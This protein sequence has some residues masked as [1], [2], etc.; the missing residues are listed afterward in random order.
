M[1]PRFTLAASALALIAAFPSVA[2]ENDLDPIVV[3]ATRQPAKENQLLS[4]VSVISRQEI[5]QAAQSTLAE[6]LGR[7]PGISFSSDGGPG[8]SQSLFIRGTN[9]DQALVLVDG[10]RLGSATLGTTALSRIPL[11][12]IDHIEILRGPASSLYGADAIGGVIQIFTRKGGGP[13]SF[14]GELAYGTNDTTRVVAGVNGSHEE[15]R[16]S[17]QYTQDKTDGFSNINDSRSYAFNKDLDGFKNESY[18]ANI[19]YNFNADHEISI[20]AFASD[21]TNRYDGGYGASASKDYKNKLNISGTSLTLR[22]RFLPDWQ[23]TLRLGQGVDNTE[24]LTDGVTAS[25]VRTESNQVQWQN[26]INLPLGKLLA[27]LEQL[28]QKV[29]ATQTYTTTERTIKSALVGWTASA[30]DNR[31]QINARRDDISNADTKNTGTVAYGYQFT[32][33]LRA[34]AS[35]GTAYK[36]PSM[37]ALYFPNTPFVGKGNPDLKPESA[38]NAEIAM[39]W[40]TATQKASATYYDNQIKDLIQWTETPPGSYFYVP[41]N[42]SK[43]RING[44]TLAYTGNFGPWKL[45]GS[46]DFLD[47]VDES[48]GHQLARRAKQ[49]GTAAVDYDAGQWAI[50]SEVVATGQRFSDAENTQRLGGYT[51]FNLYGSYR[52]DKEFS[53]FVRANNVFDKY[54][55]Q[56]QYYQ[57]PGANVLA[58]IRYSPK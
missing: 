1:Y 51:L 12:Q 27:G 23:S 11:S 47:P 41:Q 13:L 14:N 29:N 25:S 26:D 54:Y 19:G 6:L 35:A 2:A 34:S 22:D 45:H 50:G 10:I 17:F 43:A 31:W 20:N 39:H 9:S 33:T 56:V 57:T 4:D 30:G 55:E 36:A 46:A 44:L 58:G 37:N 38:T 15:F 32:D 21:G 3:T 48:S 16:Y 28:T 40:E 7:Q 42:V 8:G 52:L 49:F 18:T 5:E 53:L 24:Y